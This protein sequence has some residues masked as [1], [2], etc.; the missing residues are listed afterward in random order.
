MIKSILK[1]ILVATN[2]DGRNPLYEKINKVR[3]IWNNSTSINSIRRYLNSILIKLKYSVKFN[4]HSSIKL[5]L[6]CGTNHK[7]GFINID[8]R[9]TGATDTVCDMRKLPYPNNSVILIETY[10]A[11]EHLPRHDFETALKAWYRILKPGGK[12]VIECPDFDEIVRNYLEGDEKHL[13][14]IFGLQRFDG[15]YH[16]FG[17]NIKRLADLLKKYGFTEIQEMP[18]QDYHRKEWPCLRVECLKGDRKGC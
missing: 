2:D 11:I 3:T 4:D 14:G 13:D 1:K 9:K 16:L 18:P 6:G 8:W 10:H 5:H 17:Y 12:L 7:D 15:D